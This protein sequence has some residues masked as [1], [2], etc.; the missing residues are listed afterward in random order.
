MAK[1]LFKHPGRPE[2]IEVEDRTEEMARVMRLGYRQ[3]RDREAELEAEREAE[4]TQ[5]DG[6]K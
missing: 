4:K 5:T 3:V 2:A 6:E 1:V